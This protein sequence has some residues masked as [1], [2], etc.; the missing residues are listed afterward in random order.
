MPPPPTAQVSRAGADVT[1]IGGHDKASTDP[2]LPRG[3]GG[4]DDDTDFGNDDSDKGFPGC[5]GLQ[6]CLPET[7]P[8]G[9]GA[10]AVVYPA[11]WFGAR[12][13]AK[14][15]QTGPPGT[16]GAFAASW[17]EN[18]RRILGA[19]RHGGVVALWHYAHAPADG[20]RV[21]VMERAEGGSVDDLL[22]ASA[23]SGH[24]VAP[25]TVLDVAVQVIDALAYLHDGA[26]VVHGDIKPANLLLSQ[27]PSVDAATSTVDLPPGTVIKVGDFGVATAL[28]VV[29]PR[30][31]IGGCTPRYL[32]PECASD[33]G[34]A[35]GTGGAYSPARDVYA[36]GV[37]V[38]L[39]LVAPEF[40]AAGQGP[41]PVSATDPS[42]HRTAAG[43]TAAALAALAPVWPP[44]CGDAATTRAAMPEMEAAAQAA[45]ARNPADRPTARQLQMLFADLRAR[46]LLASRPMGGGAVVPP[47]G[48]GVAAVAADGGAALAG[49]PLTPAATGLATMATR[50]A[51]TGGSPAAVGY[52]S[53]ESLFAQA[54]AGL[55][56]PGAG[57]RPSPWPSLNPPVL[58][59][60]RERG[61]VPRGASTGLGGAVEPGVHP[62]PLVSLLPPPGFVPRLVETAS[63]DIDRAIVVGP[64]ATSDGS[65]NCPSSRGAG[66]GAGA[67]GGTSVPERQPRDV[68]ER[69]ASTRRLAAMDYENPNFGS[70]HREQWATIAL[71]VL[72]DYEFTDN[73]NRHTSKDYV[74]LYDLKLEIKSASQVASRTTDDCHQCILRDGDAGGWGDRGE[75]E[76]TGVASGSSSGDGGVNAMDIASTCSSRTGGSSAMHTSTTNSTRTGGSSAMN[77]SSTKSSG[78]RG[79]LLISINLLKEFFTIVNLSVTGE[80][81]R[82]GHG[83]VR[84]PF[85]YGL[86][87]KARTLVAAG[88]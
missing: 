51:T 27:A 65:G 13:A 79:S 49:V 6:L 29:T 22:A 81:D 42:S 28:G 12:A 34:D 85:V 16:K 3:V 57:A 37:V 70:N 39:L 69:L 71:H 30:P 45:L 26:H 63:F 83:G 66:V 47:D 61:T 48:A 23:A 53:N 50:P 59:G 74:R 46:R 33:A 35:D 32:A 80:W 19:L 87:R 9:A 44:L 4:G 31:A 62:N 17:V 86:K 7:P 58:P 41:R 64:R 72:R 68:H 36:F 10:S 38:Q 73:T 18:E 52:E 75:G 56:C 84:G 76:A 24:P 40:A 60:D 11:T 43:V 67:G 55:V 88:S 25:H 14:V 77:T 21:L 15:V 2:L 1:A 5:S 8:L 20:R 78:T 54:L 82:R